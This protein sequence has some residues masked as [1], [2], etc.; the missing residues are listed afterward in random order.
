MFIRSSIF[1]QRLRV[2]VVFKDPGVHRAYYK[3]FTKTWA[4]ILVF[5]CI[6]VYAYIYIDMYTCVYMYI[7]TYT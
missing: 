3:Y 1:E 5:I 6:Y 4:Y 2:T 7:H